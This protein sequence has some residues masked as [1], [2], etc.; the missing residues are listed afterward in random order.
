[1]SKN[2]NWWYNWVWLV[3]IFFVPMFGLWAQYQELKELRTFKAQ[4]K[5]CKCLT[6]YEVILYHEKYAMFIDSMNYASK[7]NRP[8]LADSARK[9]NELLR[10]QN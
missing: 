2:F 6:Y 3:C 7:K 5:P 8:R 9:Y 10:N 4:I 1:M